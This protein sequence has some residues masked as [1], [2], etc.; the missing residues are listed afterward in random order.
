MAEPNPTNVAPWYLRNINQALALDETTGNVYI[1][2]GI[3]GDIIIEGN[4]NIPGSV[5]V[6]SLGNVDVSGNTLPVTGNVVV[7]SLPEVE[8]KNDIGN[9]IPVTT[10][11][12]VSTV[13][14]APTQ[15]DA[16]GRFRVSNPYTLFDSQNQE[17]ID[18]QFDTAITGSGEIIY[19]PNESSVATRVLTSGDSVVRQSFRRM[20]YQPGKSLQV[21]ATFV[22]N[23][24]E[25]NLRQRIGYFD[26]QNGVFF[27]KSNGQNN[28]VLRSFVSGVASDARSVPQSSWNGDRLDGTGGANNPSGLTLDPSRA[29]ILW[30]DFEWLGVGSVRCGFV[31]NGVFYL[32]HTFHNANIINTVYMTTATLPVRYEITATGAIGTS[33]TL[34][35]ICSSVISEG[36]Y[37]DTSLDF[38][39]RRTTALTGI[40]NTFVPLVSIRLNSTALDSVVL[41]NRVLCMPTGSGFFE[42]ML[43]KNA[44]LGGSPSWS[45]VPGNT[46]VE[47][48]VTANS[49]TGGTI[50]QLDYLTS[51]NQAQGSLS[52]FTGYNWDLQLGVSLANVSDI[53]TVAIRQLSSSP[54]VGAI[55]ALSFYDLSK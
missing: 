9:A 1:R 3:T 16:F 52:E 8:I 26:T 27:E 38:V 46:D 45:S 41:P 23:T 40:A 24:A 14:F 42:V 4:V 35:Q 47:F 11:Y 31:I 49:I 19:L 25:T 20:P 18:S 54:T 32:C 34:K 2:T 13:G 21:L 36:G 29:Q 43:V 51:T 7:T 37:Q 10:S 28:F 30:M 6:E 44:T 48:D 5:A 53:Y 33:A 12:T 15:T 17:A 22:M 39:A 50:A 55:G